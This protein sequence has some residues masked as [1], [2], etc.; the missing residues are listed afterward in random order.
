MRNVEIPEEERILAL[1]IITNL[2][3]ASM[4]THVDTHR[5]WRR[6]VPCRY[7]KVGAVF[8]WEYLPKEKASLSVKT[9]QGIPLLIIQYRHDF[10]KVRSNDLCH[11]WL[12]RSFFSGDIIPS[13][14]CFFPHVH[15]IEIEGIS[16]IHCSNNYSLL[17]PSLPSSYITKLKTHHIGPQNPTF[18]R[19]NQFNTAIFTV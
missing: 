12:Q 19:G 11:P 18:R 5:H 10:G 4:F 8:L 17:L 9:L 16:L 3:H 1:L 14:L 15:S 7:C 2:W 6:Q 13:L